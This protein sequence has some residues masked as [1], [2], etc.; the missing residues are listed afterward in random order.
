MLVS[1]RSYLASA[2]LFTCWKPL[3]PKRFTWYALL[4]RILAHTMHSTSTTNSP[5]TEHATMMIVLSSCSCATRENVGVPCVGVYATVRFA[6]RTT[7]LNVYSWFCSRPPTSTTC[8]VLAGSRCQSGVTPS[9]STTL[10]SAAYSR[11]QYV[12]W[13][14]SPGSPFTP[15]GTISSASRRE[16]YT[17]YSALS[18]SAVV[19][20]IIMAIKSPSNRIS[21]WSSFGCASTVALLPGI[22]SMSDSGSSSTT[23]T[24]EKLL[25]MS[26]APY[27]ETK[28][29]P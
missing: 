16:A 15:H 4:R 1:Q 2:L 10:C 12:V 17:M 22:G 7:T 21:S 9:S 25:G 5:P 26:A 24:M 18:T 13:M 6:V 19:Y 23:A 29:S 27:T 3:R 8:S 20:R 11:P 14:Q 28:T